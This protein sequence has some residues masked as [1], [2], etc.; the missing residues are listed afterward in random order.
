MFSS[1]LPTCSYISGSLYRSAIFSQWNISTNFC[2]QGWCFGL[3][4][5][6]IFL[7][8]EKIPHIPGFKETPLLWISKNFV[9][10]EMFVDLSMINL[11][12]NWSSSYKAIYSD[13]PCLT[14]TPNPFPSLHS[15]HHQ[16]HSNS[17]V[18]TTTAAKHKTCDRQFSPSS[19][20]CMS[21]RWH[22][23]ISVDGFQS[24]SKITTRVAPIRLVPRPPIFVVRMKM[25]KWAP[26]LNS[27][28]KDIRC[29]IGVDPSIRRYTKPVEIT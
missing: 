1:S 23:W 12:L 27:S 14:N 9:G 2:K 19:S 11:L 3:A 6:N 24:G 10:Q 17:I 20:I 29:L 8:G 4:G 28:I 15:I 22:T 13:I 21:Q 18:K 26:S 16:R 25:N 7:E 5:M